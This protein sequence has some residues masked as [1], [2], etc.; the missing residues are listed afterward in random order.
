MKAPLSHAAV[1]KTHTKPF[2]RRQ[3]G[4]YLPRELG[5]TESRVA[6]GARV[7]VVQRASTVTHLRSR[8]TISRGP[9]LCNLSEI[10][11]TD[12]ERSTTV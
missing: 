11:L 9:F 8:R 4:H 6:S 5:E 3:L 2:G 12:N 1:E 7:M 10:R